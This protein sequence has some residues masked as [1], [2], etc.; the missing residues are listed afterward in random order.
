[1]GLNVRR[2]YKRFLRKKSL[3]TNNMFVLVQAAQYEAEEKALTKY[4]ERLYEEM[5]AEN[6]DSI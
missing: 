4:Y 2:I 1:M 5:L 6:I 3:Q